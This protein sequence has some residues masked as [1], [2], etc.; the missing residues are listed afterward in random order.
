MNRIKGVAIKVFRDEKKH[1]WIEYI[2]LS[3]F[4]F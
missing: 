2:K 3:M 4:T 1:I